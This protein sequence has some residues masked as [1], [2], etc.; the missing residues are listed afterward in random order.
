M[1]CLRRVANTN[2]YRLPPM[3]LVR[4][5]SDHPPSRRMRVLGL[6]IEMQAGKVWIFDLLQL[7]AN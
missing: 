2:R 6:S 5:R 1:L 7:S 3:K 4:L